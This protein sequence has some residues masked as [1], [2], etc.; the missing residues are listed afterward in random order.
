[1]S[2]DINNEELDNIIVKLIL[3]VMIDGWYL[4]TKSLLEGFI[5]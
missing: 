4:V 5:L 2:E 1:M 3:F